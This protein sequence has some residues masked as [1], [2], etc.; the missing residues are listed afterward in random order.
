MVPV[1][2]N[3]AKSGRRRNG[4]SRLF[5]SR[6]DPKLGPEICAARAPNQWSTISGPQIVD[7]PSGFRYDAAMKKKNIRFFQYDVLL[8]KEDVCDREKEIAALMAAAKGNRRIVLLAPRRYG[9]TSLVRNVVGAAMA[10][11]RPKRLVLAVD[12][13]GVESLHSIAARL[14][15]GLGRALAESFSPA[16]LLK[17]AADLFRKLSMRIDVDPV[18][19]APSVG[20]G[21]ASGDDRKNI[22]SL[23]DGITELSEKQPLMLILDEFQDIAFVPEAEGI[24]R[25]FLQQ[26]SRASVFILGSKRHLMERMLGNAN[27]PLFQFGDE[28]HL[29]PIPFEAWKPYFSERLKPFGADISS[30]GLQYLLDRMCHVPN[31]VCELGAWIQERC[32]GRTL[33]AADVEMAL[34]D[35]VETKQG[36]AYRLMNMSEGEKELLMCMAR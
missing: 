25:A 31:A 24:M 22:L 4:Y 23:L 9:K 14:E 17:R 1:R 11:A 28:M 32:S 30:D 18:T 27:A 10:E 34:N 12:F 21:L 36:Y 20:I 5:L 16:N 6:L 3:F 7:N 19:G 29:D 26:L 13:M 33:K 2:L 35:M 15:H 8:D